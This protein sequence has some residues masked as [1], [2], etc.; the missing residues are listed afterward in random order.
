MPQQFIA[1]V[2]KADPVPPANTIVRLAVPAGVATAAVPGQFL[3]LQSGGRD[4]LLPRP[5]SIMRA[6]RAAREGGGEGTLD[7]LV[8]TGGRGGNHLAEARAGDPF[9][10]LGPLGNGYAIDGRMRRALLIAV[11]HGI[12]PIIA[13][14]E[15]AL[16]RGV[17]VVML[18]GAP[19]AAS[20]LPLPLLPEEAEIIVATADGSRGHHGA[21]TDL[22]ANYIEW[23][24]AIYAYAPETTYVALRETLRGYRGARAIP[25]VQ[26]AMERSMACGMGVC[27]GCVV[28]T[29]SGLKTVCRDGPIFPLD[30]L[31]LG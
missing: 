16:A 13:L 31:V 9:P 19:T 14:A 15:S 18:V 2:V 6:T 27:L 24:D 4:P 3:M 25:P 8:F 5:Y 10:I 29:T 17:E 28:E 1:R 20:L 30:A 23:T 7:L 11:G 21:V 12:A 26:A 22:V